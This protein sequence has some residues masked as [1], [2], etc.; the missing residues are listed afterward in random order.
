ML[1]AFLV[2]LLVATALTLGLA[3]WQTIPAGAQTTTTEAPATTT[4]T[5]TVPPAEPPA[6]PPPPSE[7]WDAGTREAFGWVALFVAFTCGHLLTR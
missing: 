7:S 3:A 4:T 6:D 2:S 5:T 1:R